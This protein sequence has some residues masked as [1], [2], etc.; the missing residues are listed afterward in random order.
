MKQRRRDI[1]R[2]A[3]ELSERGVVGMPVFARVLVSGVN[4]YKCL[5]MISRQTRGP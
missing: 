3:R 4:H 2:V 1:F 5:A